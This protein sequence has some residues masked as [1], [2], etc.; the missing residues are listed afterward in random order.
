MSHDR[1]PGDMG[2]DSS[3]HTQQP[4]RI[5]ELAEKYGQREATGFEFVGEWVRRF[6]E[7]WNGH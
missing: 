2:R 4:E 7:K 6:R 1:L 3:D 5:E